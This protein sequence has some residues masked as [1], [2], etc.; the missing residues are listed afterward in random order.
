MGDD[1]FLTEEQEAQIEAENQSTEEEASSAAQRNPFRVLS[2]SKY[3]ND[4]TCESRNLC[5]RGRIFS[6]DLV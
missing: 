2:G 5:H 3:G 1:I 4:R 6:M